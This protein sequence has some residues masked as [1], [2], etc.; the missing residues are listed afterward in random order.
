MR[1]HLNIVGTVVTVV[2]SACFAALI[3]GL[4]F[5]KVQPDPFSATDEPVTKVKLSAASGVDIAKP[6]ID[7]SG[8]QLP[9][10]MDYDTISQQITGV[11]VR[12]QHGISMKKKNNAAYMNGKDKAM[13]THIKEFQKRNIPVA[14]YAYVNG[15]SVAEMK[16]EAD[17]F[18]ERAAKYKPVYWWLDVEE[19]TMKKDFNKGIEAFRAE[20]AKKGAKNIGIYTQD[21]FVTANNL[22]VTSFDSVWLAHYGGDTGYWDSSPDTTIPYDLHQY[23][24]R[25]RLNGFSGDLDFNRVTSV[26]DYNKIF[27]KGKLLK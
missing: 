3:I 22:T 16:K 6:I 15:N 5:T 7:I 14:V 13:A 8:W 19:V 4:S 17:K 26:A 1:K 21:W 11:I 20:L 25:G 23:T 9:S 18:Y 2:L 10:D 27:N 24:S 12:V